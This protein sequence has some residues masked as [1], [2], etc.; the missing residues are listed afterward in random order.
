MSGRVEVDT[1]K[2]ER[3]MRRLADGLDKGGQSVAR[4]HAEQTAAEIR[5][6]VP[7]RTGRLAAS[8]QVVTVPGGYGVA[9]GGTLPYA[10]YIEHRTN[11][12]ADAVDGAADRYT[13]DQYDLARTETRHA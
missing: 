7:R 6:N 9:Y 2:L 10:R 12:V 11:T 3:F 1:S 4:R 5:G 8:V 13:A